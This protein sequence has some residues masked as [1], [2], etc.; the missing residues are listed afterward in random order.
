MKCSPF[1]IKIY[2]ITNVEPPGPMSENL[3]MKTSKTYGVIRMHRISNLVL[4][5]FEKIG[6]ISLLFE[7]LS[8]YVPHSESLF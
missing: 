6:R 7:F 4:K 5:S 2:A 8:P 3:V 1:E